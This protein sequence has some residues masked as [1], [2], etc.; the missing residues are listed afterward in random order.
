MSDPRPNT[1]L[2][3]EGHIIDSMIHP[4]VMDMVMDL[5]PT[6]SGDFAGAPIL[7]RAG[8]SPS[9]RRSVSP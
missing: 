6:K 4:K 8:R 2:V 5:H 3:L 1:L 9:P 7:R